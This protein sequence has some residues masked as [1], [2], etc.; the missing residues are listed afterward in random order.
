MKSMSLPTR[1]LISA[2]LAIALVGASFSDTQMRYREAQ[3]LDAS[4]IEFDES[5]VRWS[6]YAWTLESFVETDSQSPICIL[7]NGDSNDSGALRNAW[8]LAYTHPDGR[9]GLRVWANLWWRPSLGFDGQPFWMRFVV[10]QNDADF[11]GEPEPT[12]FYDETEPTIR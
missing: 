12:V 6:G 1:L 9:V 5:L 11:Y 7:S 8:C 2:L 10:F 4:V 3:N